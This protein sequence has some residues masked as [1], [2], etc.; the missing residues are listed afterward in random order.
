MT[1]IAL[2][3][4]DAQV[5]YT[6]R[7]HRP[8][9]RDMLRGQR[10]AAQK[11]HALR[12][13]TFDVLVG[14]SVG[15]VGPNGS[16]KTTMLQATT[17]L[18]PVSAGEILVRSVPTFLGV[19]AVLRNQLTGRRNIEIGLLAQGLDRAGVDAIS[20]PGGLKEN[21]ELVQVTSLLWRRAAFITVRGGRHHDARHPV[22]ER[23]INRGR[24]RLADQAKEVFI[25]YLAE[26]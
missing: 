23:C 11:V 26:E 18:L 22:S 25:E 14:E 19:Q 3:C 6:I 13:V 24:S 12:G 16:G 20:R 2:R 17:G 9:I 8:L 15:V 10:P 1:D 5:T 21:G 7:S 4:V